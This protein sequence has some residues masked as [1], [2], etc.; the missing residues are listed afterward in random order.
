GLFGNREMR[1]ELRDRAEA[2]PE[3]WLEIARIGDL[4]LEE[5]TAAQ[6]PIGMHPFDRGAIAVALCISRIIPGARGPDS[7]IEEIGARI[8]GI[9][10]GVE[11]IGRR[12]FAD[13]D[14]DAILVLPIGDL[15]LIRSDL[16]RL[17]AEAEILPHEQPRDVELRIVEASFLRLAIRKAG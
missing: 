16:L 8:A 11:K 14:G 10:V 2:V 5:P 17:A 7:A 15:I 3:A 13:G 4:R 12:I 6:G 1:L 9:I